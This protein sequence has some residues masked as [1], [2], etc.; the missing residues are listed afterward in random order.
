MPPDSQGFLK[1]PK[2]AAR[3]ERPGPVI[4]D[5]PAG[6]A[7]TGELANPAANTVA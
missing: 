4:R 2:T 7:S 3:I 1:P 5:P 6:K